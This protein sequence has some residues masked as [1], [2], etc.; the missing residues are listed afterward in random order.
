M[1]DVTIWLGSQKIGQ[2]RAGD[3]L[4]VEGLLPG[5]YRVEGRKITCTDQVREVVYGDGDA[6]YRLR[7]RLTA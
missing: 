6:R 1:S 5:T 2:T 7:Y 4:L 3:P